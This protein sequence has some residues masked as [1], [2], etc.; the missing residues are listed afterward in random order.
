M[1][2]AALFDLPRPAMPDFDPA[3]CHVAPVGYDTAR[4]VIADAHY[5][6]RPGS[7]SVALGLYV[8]GVL[9]GVITYGTI[10]RNNAEAICGPEHAASVLELTRLALYDWL[11]RNS[12]S[13]LISQSFRWLRQHRPDVRLLISY[14]DQAQG[15]VGTIYQATNWIYTGASTGD[16]VYRLDDGTV[17]HPRTLGWADLPAGK[18]QPSPAK[19]RY[20]HLLGSKSQRKAL[21]A[22]LRWPSL[23][24]PKEFP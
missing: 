18:W 3:R 20:V 6:G 9:G 1:I 14:A 24:Y 12:E 21:R 13:W 11:P 8:D 22:A 17:L 16:V 19:H 7:T 2:S 15:H 23:P 10:P 4:L 5:I